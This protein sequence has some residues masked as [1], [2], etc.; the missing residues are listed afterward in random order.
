[1]AR[2]KALE[3][4]YTPTQVRTAITKHL[5]RL[6]DSTNKVQFQAQL[7]EVEMID[8]LAD[9]ARTEDYP[10][11]LRRQCALDVLNYARGQPK[12]WLHDGQ[13]VDPQAQGN[14]GLGATV[15]QEI[16]AAKATADLH[17][18]VAQLT[19]ANVH[20]SEWD[21]EV[22]SVAGDIVEYYENTDEKV[23]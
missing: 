12:T 10:L 1:M 14:S 22:R 17:A 2:A 19:A 4:T 8:L 20:P 13:T 5:K 18:K 7:Y 9:F 16:E 11:S 23:P 15:I 3:L 6:N 21:E